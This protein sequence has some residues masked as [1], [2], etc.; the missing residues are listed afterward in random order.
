MSN[1]SGV[2]LACSG[3]YDK[4]VSGGANSKLPNTHGYRALVSACDKAF[5]VAYVQLADLLRA[6]FDERGRALTGGVE[7]R[8]C[9]TYV[10]HMGSPPYHFVGQVSAIPDDAFLPPMPTKPLER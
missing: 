10:N 4:D 6:R 8:Y 3:T 7:P 2:V 9:G 1:R 5:F